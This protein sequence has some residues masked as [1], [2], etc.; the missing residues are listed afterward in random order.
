MWISA[1]G[2]SAPGWRR[3]VPFVALAAPGTSFPYPPKV[4][5]EIGE[6]RQDPDAIEWTREIATFASIPAK[7]ASDAPREAEVTGLIRGHLQG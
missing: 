7:A 1:Y 2:A 5:I 3:K 6:P 4:S